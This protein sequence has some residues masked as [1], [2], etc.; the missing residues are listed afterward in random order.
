MATYHYIQLEVGGIQAFLF[1]AGKLKEMIGASE[2]VHAFT[3]SLFD[4]ACKDLGLRPLDLLEDSKETRAPADADWICP[5][6][7]NA[8]TLRCLTADEGRARAFVEGFSRLAL[9]CY[10]GLPFFGAVV[11]CEYTGDGLNAARRKLADKIQRQR[12]TFPVPCGMSLVPFVETAPLDGLPAAFADPAA[13]KEGENP[14]VSLLS[15]TRHDRKLLKSSGERLRKTYNH[16]VIAAL[17]KR[18]IDVDAD[19]VRWCDDLEDMLAGREK[20]RVALIHM[21]GNDLGIRFRAALDE[22]KDCPRAGR[23][24]AQ[25]LSRD[26]EDAVEAAFGEAVEAAVQNDAALPRNGKYAVPLRPLVLGG[27]D[28]TVIVRADLALPFVRAFAAAFESATE[29]RG[30]RCS[31]GAG[32]VATPAGYP[33]AKAWTLCEDLCRL[34]KRKT[35]AN[36]PE[37]GNRPSSLD[38]LVLTSD[39]EG[40]VTALRERTARADDGKNLTCKPF[41]L[42]DAFARFLQRGEKALRCLPR[43]HLREAVE[44]CR[45]GEKASA[46]AYRKLK[47]NIGRGI[48]GRHNAGE[49]SLEEFETLLP[50]FFREPDN[51]CPL[52]DWLELPHLG[53]GEPDA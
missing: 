1:A 8:G 50:G 14:Y 28:I 10:P 11:P 48:G 38:W 9:E 40:S 41:L 37:R 18:G 5:L 42:N 21:D 30:A 32:M 15:H 44:L 53:I 6:Q 34:A 49:L 43:V 17:Q 39:V 20:K 35:A 36:D 7:R 25:K 51:A 26:I 12:A 29:A 19:H 3:H 47:E 45:A 33:F 24:A 4:Q 22:H 13:K 2:C 27:D 23:K 46:G 31:V 16:N 52:S